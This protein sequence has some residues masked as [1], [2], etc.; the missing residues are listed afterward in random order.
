[1]KNFYCEGLIEVNDANPNAQAAEGAQPRENSLHYGVISEAS[2]LRHL[3]DWL[4]NYQKEQILHLKRE[5]TPDYLARNT[6]FFENPTIRDAILNGRDQ[7]EIEE[8]ARKEFYDVRM[9]GMCI[10][11][12]N[13]KEAS[14]E[15]EGEEK[16]RPEKKYPKISA[17]SKKAI[18]IGDAESVLPIEKVYVS[19][20]CSYNQKQDG[21]E[22][23]NTTYNFGHYMVR[24]GLYV[25]KGGIPHYAAERNG[26]SEADKDLLKEAMLSLYEDDCSMYRPF[27]HINLRGLVIWETDR[28]VKPCQVYDTLKII[29][30]GATARTIHDY[31]IS[32]AELEGVRANVYDFGANIK[33]T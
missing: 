20:S 15:T 5:D 12:S 4:I 24:H 13:K 11:N 23:E 2:L 7:R 22:R 25:F 21:A 1:M 27:G 28:R 17:Y 19:E 14:S 6:V 3:K 18:G 9:F 32:L 8:V 31:D 29:P 16:A 30:R 33:R 10:L 26:V